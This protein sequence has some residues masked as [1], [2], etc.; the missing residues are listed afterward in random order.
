MY[1]ADLTFHQLDALSTKAINGSVTSD[2]YFTDQADGSIDQLDTLSI[3]AINGSVMSDDYL[4]DQEDGT[5]HEQQ[6]MQLDFPKLEYHWDLHDAK[7]TSWASKE[8]SLV[9]KKLKVPAPQT[10]RGVY[11]SPFSFDTAG[12]FVSFDSYSH[13]QVQEGNC[14]FTNDPERFMPPVRKRTR[15]NLGRRGSNLADASKPS[16]GSPIPQDKGVRAVRFNLAPN[17]LPSNPDQD[18]KQHKH[19][20]SVC[21]NTRQLFK[22]LFKPMKGH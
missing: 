1:R 14:A 10:A 17:Q 4:A 3:R 15:T 11:N 22:D 8:G 12:D 2:D 7:D 6:S 20:L 13:R 19:S 16:A 18:E 9:N 5:I 21:Q